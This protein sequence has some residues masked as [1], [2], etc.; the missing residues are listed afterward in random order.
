MIQDPVLEF[1]ISSIW[2]PLVALKLWSSFLHA[3]EVPVTLTIRNRIRRLSDFSS[4]MSPIQYMLW[5]TLSP[6]SYI[7]PGAFALCN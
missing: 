2:S 4:A 7:L 5:E 6:L 3:H 1:L